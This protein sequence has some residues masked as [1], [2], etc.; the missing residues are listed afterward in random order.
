MQ[1]SVDPQP[2]V[3]ERFLEQYNRYRRS[4]FGRTRHLSANTIVAEDRDSSVQRFFE[5]YLLADDEYRR[6]MERYLQLKGSGKSDEEIAASTGIPV[7][8]YRAVEYTLAETMAG[9][10]AENYRQQVKRP[11]PTTV[12][13]W[14][15][16]RSFAEPM[17]LPSPFE[18]SRTNLE[19][20]ERLISATFSRSVSSREFDELLVFE[21][22]DR[23]REMKLTT[24]ARR[25]A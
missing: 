7:S 17:F 10:L 19:N 18:P 5:F 2:E 22:P 13:L 4:S 16:A 21:F 20:A 15:D 3:V 25:L 6:Q 24:D 23:L 14:A 9:R 8:S 11:Q 1:A 12:V